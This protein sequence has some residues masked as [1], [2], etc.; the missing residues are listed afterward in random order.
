VWMSTFVV[1][2]WEGIVG[3]ARVRFADGLGGGAGCPYRGSEIGSS[4]ACS[5]GMIGLRFL[6]V[7]GGETEC[8][9]KVPPLHGPTRS[10]TSAKEK[11]SGCFGRDD[12]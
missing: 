5:V 8:S 9:A 4:T 7:I 10:R 2:E 12:R 3:V 6:Q 1:R 11:A